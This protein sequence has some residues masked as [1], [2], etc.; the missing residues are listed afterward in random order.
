MDPSRNPGGG[1]LVYGA[2]QLN[3]SQARDP[4]LVYDAREDDYVRMLCAE[5]YNSTQLRAVTGSDATACPAAATSGGT[6]ADLNYPTMAHLAKPGKNFTIHFPRTI[7][8]VGAP[9]SVYTAKIAGL[10]PYIRVAVKPRRLA[11]SRLLQKVSFTVTVSGALPDANEFVSAAV[12]WSDGVRQVRSPIIVHT[13]DVE[14]T[15]K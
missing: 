13:V 5:G 1:E 6:T 7:T 15:P 8:N 2:G 12:V 14:Y 9:G 3:P 4:G 10:G 11:F